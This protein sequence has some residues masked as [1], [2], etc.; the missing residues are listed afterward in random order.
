MDYYIIHFITAFLLP[1]GNILLLFVISVFLFKYNIEYAR[2]L[3][4]VSCTLFYLICTPA[5]ATIMISLL[6]SYPPINEETIQNHNAKAIVILGGGREGIAL[7][8]GKDITN[9]HTFERLRYGAHLQTK[10]KLPILVTGGF[11]DPKDTPE[12]ILM[13]ES[14]ERDFKIKAEWE[15]NRSRNTAEN[16]IFSW[17]I[18]EKENINTIFLVSKAWH[19]PR[20]VEIFERQGFTVIPA[21]TGFD[22]FKSSDGMDFSDFM[23]SGNAVK[24]NYYAFHELVGMIWYFIRY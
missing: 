18:L 10:T 23:P 5:V 16:A 22:G 19:L 13:S 9:L 20:A 11:I 21:P 8:Y 2:R 24:T 15:E 3:L 6:E 14:L 1:P 12:G 7:E 17:E 4:I